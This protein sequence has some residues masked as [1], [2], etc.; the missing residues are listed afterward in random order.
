LSKVLLALLLVVSKPLSDEKIMDEE[1]SLIV[2]EHDKFREIKENM[3]AKVKLSIK[4]RIKN[5]KPCLK[6]LASTNSVVF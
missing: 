4:N 3:R 5:L 2:F 6:S 1:Y